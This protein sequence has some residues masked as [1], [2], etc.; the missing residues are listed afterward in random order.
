MDHPAG[1]LFD[2]Q[3]RRSARDSR[4]SARLPMP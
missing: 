4:G 1:R 3:Q 2:V